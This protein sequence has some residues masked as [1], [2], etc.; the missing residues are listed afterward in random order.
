MTTSAY[1]V[2]LALSTLGGAVIV[3]E[4]ASGPQ[5]W[6]V[7]A[8]LAAVVIGIGGKL[9][10]TA[11]KQ[12]VAVGDLAMN[13]KLLAAQMAE[14]TRT[15]TSEWHMLKADLLQMPTKVADEVEKSRRAS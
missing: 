2:G 10:Q 4:T 9:V 1:L 8:L 14:D 11:E 3:Y 5:D 12:V 7:L 6:T 15:R 13:V